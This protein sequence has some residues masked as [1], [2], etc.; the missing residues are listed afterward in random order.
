MGI[1]IKNPFDLSA[2]SSQDTYIRTLLT[3]EMSLLKL[4]NKM[5]LNWLTMMSF[6][7]LLGETGYF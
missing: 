3:L 7:V 1:K 2:K 4:F 6:F 5:L